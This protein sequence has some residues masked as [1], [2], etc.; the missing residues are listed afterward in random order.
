MLCSCL[1][2]RAATVSPLYAR[3]YTVLP[4]PQ[5]V[6]LGV[7]DF[8]FDKN[9]RIQTGPGVAANDIAIQSLNDELQSR[10]QIALDRPEGSQT[11][12]GNV[13][14]TILP[15]SVTVGDATDRDKT[16]LAEQAYK[17]ILTKD[18]VS[19]TANASPGLFYG[20]QTFVQLLKVQSGSLWL[21]EGEIVDWPDLE[22]R[23]IY[24]DDAHHLERPGVLER[25]IRQAAFY[26][27]NGFAIKL[28]G[29]FQYKS[30]A[31]IVEPYALTPA[32]LQ[33]LTD[34]ALKYHIQLIPY[35]DGPAHV[36]FILKH[37]EYNRLRE[38]PESNYEFC[39][40]NPDTYNLLFRMFQDLLDANRGSKYF[41]LST[42]EPYYIGLAKNAQ[43]NEADRA[44]ELGSVGKLLGEFVTKTAAYLHDRGRTVVFWGEYP[45]V[46]G[47]ISSFPPYLVNGELYGPAFD[48]VFKSHGIRQMVYT[49]TE[50]EEP[51]FPEYYSLPNTA[52]LHPR[53]ITGG[54]V[55]GMFEAISKPALET[56]APGELVGTVR[57]GADVMG[58]LVAGWADAGLHPETFW[59]GYATGSAAAWHPISPGPNE[60]MSSFYRLFYGPSAADMGRVY[61]LMS[62][63]AEFWDDSWEWVPSS[64]RTPLFGNSKGISNPPRPEID[65]TLPPLPVPA[66][67]YLKL[68]H[69]WSLENTKRLELASKFL[70]ENDE[71]LDLLRMNIE[72]VEF[73]RYNLEVFLSIA[74]LCRQNLDM[75]LG[76]GRIN[77]LL[78]SAAASASKHNATDAVVALDKALNLAEAIREQR[79]AALK[80]ASATWY[81]T[82]LPRVAEANGRRYLNL[83][84]DVKDH[85]PVRTV[86]MSY[87]EYRELL[88]PLGEWAEQ[89]QAVR[90]S[91]AQANQLP[92]RDGKLD[93]KNRGTMV[94]A[95]LTQ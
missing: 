13:R 67:A 56:R 21:P 71:L 25:A 92:V 41:V 16:A 95:G 45:M 64:A 76:L 24:W 5:R 77:D 74:Q 78:K 61:Q 81:K 68:N 10:F 94:T 55:Q 86:D 88:L 89:V 87:L 69:D 34:E 22:L 54:R 60:L 62:E 47:D 75:V 15:K 90:N 85:R 65:Q 1:A 28:E 51:L 2:A 91:Y 72:R 43:C 23:I 38:Y 37:P 46:P 27:I 44:R 36:A 14:L 19:I 26:K 18:N 83:V 32:E 30:A 40:T 12:A 80:D 73:N 53:H 79:N 66:T 6:K 57:D 11:S 33:G 63:Q 70:T 52:L 8:R 7:S 4:S 93:W 31:P 82:W 20:V 58:T 39:A 59:L 42:D 3:G 49:S 48:P 35:L 17:I 29:H 9:W 84:D 50:G